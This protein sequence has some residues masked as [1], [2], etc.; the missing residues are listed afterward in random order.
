[1]PPDPADLINTILA[2]TPRMFDGAMYCGDDEIGEMIIEQPDHPAAQRVLGH[3]AAVALRWVADRWKDGWH[4][5][6][7]LRELADQLDT[8]ETP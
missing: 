8:Q 7:D 1:M 4:R 5:A 2:A 3:Q 6:D